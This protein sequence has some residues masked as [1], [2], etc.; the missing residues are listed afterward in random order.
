L[1]NVNEWKKISDWKLW[2]Y[3]KWS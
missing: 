1:V 3:Y 2:V